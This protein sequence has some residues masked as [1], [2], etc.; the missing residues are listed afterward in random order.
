[1]GDPPGPLPEGAKLQ[2]KLTEAAA[3]KL[4][5]GDY[6]DTECAGLY[7]RITRAGARTYYCVT[8]QKDSRKV[9]WDRIGPV[10][11]IALDDARREVQRRRGLV[12]AGVDFAV[13]RARR[14]SEPTLGELMA[15]YFAARKGQRSVEADRRDLWELWLGE[16]PDEPS[17]KHGRKR[18]KPAGSV[19]WSKRRAGSITHGEIKTLMAAIATTGKQ[20]TAGRV[21]ELVHAA[22]AWGVANHRIS[23]NPAAGI[24]MPNST[25]RNRFVHTGEMPVLLRAISKMPDPW[26][27]LFS[28]FLLIGYRRS[29]IQRMAWADIMLADRIW[30]VPSSD[31]KNAEPTPLPLSAPALAI[32]QKRAKVNARRSGGPCKWVFPGSTAAGHVGRP[33]RAWAALLTS[34]GLADLRPHDMRRTLGSHLAMSGE[35]LPTIAKVL[36]HKDVKST[37]VYA[38]FQLDPVRKALDRVHVRIGTAGTRRKAVR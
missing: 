14:R 22:Y 36:G 23:V 21:H 3:R 32:L 18:V 35:S 17:K 12:A 31:S 37:Q 15:E 29:A 5:P 13:E 24:E 1:M 33:K 7:L 30:F 2:T 9:V 20:R 6:Q 38:K 25:E 10:G 8:W 27:D 34:C 4:T 11:G 19:N 26:G 16:L 28:L